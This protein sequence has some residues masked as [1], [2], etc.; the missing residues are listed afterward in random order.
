MKAYEFLATAE[1]RKDC[2]TN[3][4]KDLRKL[5]A[6]PPRSTRGICA[7]VG[8]N[9]I[10][11][12]LWKDWPEHSGNAKFPVPHKNGAAP[13][14]V[15]SRDDEMWSPK[16]AYG[17]ARLRLLDYLIEETGR[18]IDALRKEAHH[19]KRREAPKPDRRLER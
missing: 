19:A 1:E 3:L 4:R 7:Y 2:L 18:W 15:T 17:A 5:R 11:E 6:S 8:H 16:Y 9:A 14:F 10:L 12:E 13:A